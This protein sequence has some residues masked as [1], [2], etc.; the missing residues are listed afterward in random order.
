M[1]RD[2][3]PDRVRHHARTR[4]DRPA[5]YFQDQ[6]GAWRPTSWGEYGER[7]MDFAGA[8]LALGYGV[9]QGVAIVSNNRPEWII[10][11]TGAMIARAVPA[12]IYPTLTPDQVA[13]VARHCEAKVVVVEDATQW[14][15]L[16]AERANLPS[17]ER[18]VMIVGA[19]AVKDARVIGFEAF[20]AG[21]RAHREAAE[22]RFSELQDEDL[23]TLIYTSGTTGPPKGVMLSHASLAWTSATA[24][25]VVGAD[26]D[27]DCMVSYLPLSHIA[28]Q[29]FSVHLP[30]TAGYPIW[31][32]DRFDKLKDTL[33]AA[34]PT[35][36]MGVPRVWEKFGAA[37]EKKLSEATGLKAAIIA[38]ARRVGTR[39]ADDVVRHGAPSGL[40]GLQYRLAEKLFYGK[41]REQLGL[42][43]LRVAVTGAAPIG[44]DVLAFFQSLGILIHEVYGQS[45]DCGPTTFNQPRPGKR[46][47][48]TV[49][50]PFPGVD[51]RIADDGEILVRGPNVFAGYYKEPEATA[52]ALSPDGWL[53]S[54]DIGDFD[55]EGF[56]RITDRKKDLIITAGGKNVAPQ[57]IE[58]LL[59][60]IAG[61][62]QAVVLGDQRK[63]LTALLTIDAEAGPAV[64]QQRGWPTE[65]AALAEHPEFQAHVQRGVDTAN[66]E[67]A[68]YEQIKRWRLL[69]VDFSVEGGELTPT[70][71][72]KRKV[73]AQRYA[74]EINGLYDGAG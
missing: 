60:G 72:V 28:E 63:Y 53:H 71:K 26:P 21:G 49:G 6:G 32:T 22:A 14:A 38:W 59:K 57:N 69:P 68:R 51:V 11:A 66:A 46:K 29:M 33:V 34:R 64:A 67:L 7:A 23:G 54:G 44:K 61:V 42:D 47:P 20:L 55:A 27:V 40:L 35:L 15:K 2:T 24:R 8:L 41:L 74:N 48:G 5:F 17:L 70:Q 36:F 13:Y 37:L 39:A 31:I 3:I 16:E 19:D 52:E 10:A 9:G 50:L 4:A 18:V 62:G 73:V 45:E 12:G 25:Q 30:A 43:R 1:S 56:L 58:K 65:P